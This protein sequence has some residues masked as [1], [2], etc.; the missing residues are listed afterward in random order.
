M[1]EIVGVVEVGDS[2]RAAFEYRPAVVHPFRWLAEDRRLA[3][4]PFAARQH[5]D[6]EMPRQAP[7]HPHREE[8]EV[9][10]AEFE[11]LRR[12]PEAGL[13]LHERLALGP[14]PDGDDQLLFEQFL[15]V[16]P[17]VPAEQHGHDPFD[18]VLVAE[19]RLLPYL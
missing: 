14:G 3:H 8:A 15:R 11:R 19:P 18:A 10:L 7:G 13:Q 5:A 6:A 12:R 2:L 17:V 4:G 1:T 9:R 16:V